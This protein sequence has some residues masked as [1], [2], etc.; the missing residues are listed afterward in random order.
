MRDDRR[1]LPRRGGTGAEGHLRRRDLADEQQQR[2][3]AAREAPR[4]D[5]REVMAGAEPRRKF[6]RARRAAGTAEAASGL[7]EDL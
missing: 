4:V 3:A 7:S 2:V 6:L 1:R 5:D